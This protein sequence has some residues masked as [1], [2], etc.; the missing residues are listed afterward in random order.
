MGSPTKKSASELHSLDQQLAGTGAVLRIGPIS[1]RVAIG[2]PSIRQQFLKIYQDYC[3][4]TEPEII[5]HRLT[6]YARNLF[7]RYIRPQATINTL[8]NDDFVPLP[9]SMGLLSVEMGMNWQVAFGCK[10]HILFHA[11]VVERDGIGLIIP[12]ISGSGKSTLSAGLSYDGWRFFSDEFG[13][14]D[15]A[16]GMLYPYPRPVSLKNESIAVMK[17][18]VKDETCFSP[19]Y[20]KTPKGTICYLRPPVDSLKRMDE[21]ARPRLVIHPIFDPNAT[22]SCRRLTQTMAFFRLVRSSANY[23]D[24][25]EAAFAALSQL[26]AECQSYEITYSTLEE[27][28]VLVNQIVDD[29]A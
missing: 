27:A 2:F 7:R 1:T 19:E 12:A 22:P 25:G 24:I 13:M 28:I 17:A 11:G 9:E 20:R 18:W 10:T 5:D 8:M 3:F 14:L 4:P 26:S 29:L 16:S 15:P 6:V 21:P 23:G